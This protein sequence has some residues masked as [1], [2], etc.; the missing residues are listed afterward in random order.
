[1]SIIIPPWILGLRNCYT[2][3]EQV[4]TMCYPTGSFLIHFLTT[5][6]ALT[7]VFIL[8][9]EYEHDNIHLAIAPAHMVPPTVAAFNPVF[10]LHHE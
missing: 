3:L 1:M 10:W 4:S 7:R 2:R 5:D 6:I 8:Y 9:L